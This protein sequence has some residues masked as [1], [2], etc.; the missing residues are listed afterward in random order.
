MLRIGIGLSFYEDFDSLRRMLMSC[1][2]Y[3]IDLI[4][5]V[6][7]KYKGYPTK[8]ELSSKD[9]KGLLKSFQTPV[10]YYAMGGESDQITKRQ[11]YMDVCEEHEIDCLIIMDSDE[12]FI[13]EKT[14]WPLFIED[15]KQKIKD[16]AHTWRHAYCLPVYLKDKGTEQMEQGYYE[17]LPRIFYKPW[18]L[19]Y[20]DDHYTIR[21]KKTGVMMTFEGNS[22]I[23][24]IAMGHDHNLRSKDTI[25]TPNNMRKN[26]LNTRTV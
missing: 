8:N 24:N 6:D 12:Y 1:E 11:L 17:N 10:Q 14:N 26:L 2:S 19:R 13:H 25:L 20:V 3:P 22:V 5:A 15:L 7:G 16:D 9:V 18:E 21:N 23:S 4:I